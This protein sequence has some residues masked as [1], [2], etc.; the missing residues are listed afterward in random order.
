MMFVYSFPR[1]IFK[2]PPAAIRFGFMNRF[3][4][5]F[6]CC[7]SIR[8]TCENPIERAREQLLTPRID[9]PFPA[10]DF[11][12]WLGDRRDT[13]ASIATGD[14]VKIRGEQLDGMNG[15]RRFKN[16]WRGCPT[17]STHILYPHRSDVTGAFLISQEAQHL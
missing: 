4:R 17:A 6:R 15:R 5:R 10:Y 11:L 1:S 13:R 2:L 14:S 8:L 3:R 16:E 7:W 12:R 9:P